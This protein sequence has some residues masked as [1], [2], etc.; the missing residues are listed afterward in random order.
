MGKQDTKHKNT[1]KKQPHQPHKTSKRYLSSTSSNET[2][3]RKNTRRNK[4]SSSSVNVFEY[5]DSFPDD[6]SPTQITE[7]RVTMVTREDQLQSLQ[8]S[9]DRISDK[10]GSID[11]INVKLSNI[12][13]KIDVYCER[14][15][16]IE[17]RL[18]NIVP[19]ISNLSN[20][21]SNISTTLEFLPEKCVIMTP[22][23]FTPGEQL[24]DIANS[25]LQ[26]ITPRDMSH[27]EAQRVKRV[28]FSE[29]NSRPGM[30]LV[31]LNNVDD[32][33]TIL[34]NTRAL[35]F[36]TNTS[37]R[38]IYVRAA[39]S[40]A[41]HKM[42]KNL[43]RLMDVIPGANERFML[44][45]N[46]WLQQRPLNQ[47]VYSAQ[48]SN[49]Q[50]H[51]Y[52]NNSQDYRYP[53]QHQQQFNPHF[54]NNQSWRHQPSHNQH[55]QRGHGSSNYRYNRP[56]QQTNHRQQPPQMVTSPAR[57]ATTH[58]GSPQHT[59]METGPHVIASDRQQT[60]LQ[61]PQLL[62]QH[63]QQTVEQP[64]Q[65]YPQQQ[66]QQSTQQ[67]LPQ[68]HQQPIQQPPQHSLQQPQQ[69]PIQQVGQQS[70]QQPL[71]QPHQQPIQ[72]TPNHSLQQPRQQ[73]FQQP[74]QQP[75]Q[76]VPNQ[77]PHSL[78]SSGPGAHTMNM[79][80]QSASA[81]YNMSNNNNVT[82]QQTLF[83][84]QNMGG[85]PRRDVPPEQALTVMQ[86]VQPHNQ[87]IEHNNVHMNNS[88]LTPLSNTAS[89]YSNAANVL[90]NGEFPVLQ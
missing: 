41:E 86:T 8:N 64:L 26:V 34:S 74:P 80:D 31:E 46:G 5:L 36:C 23:P 48:G 61:Q 47:G 35:K 4:S 39:K 19:E 25:V 56:T 9:I 75:P 33:R 50:V 45:S 28:N 38:A 83:Q 60:H 17:N 72:Q 69:Q 63:S 52:N 84:S 2:P 76:Q 55:Y 13:H 1:S 77:N 18:D 58:T 65:Q 40:Y 12:E 73:L 82:A 20:K 49:T 32:R 44:S 62:T 30:L 71:T 66:S 42:E 3:S 81:L 53:S 87:L 27:I 78:S 22:V 67:P 43:R 70:P 11:Q 57:I 16:D 79:I 85:K 51:S 37:I 24:V 6:Y 54:M 89:V 68:P 10:L 90:H 59:S 14:V 15:V 29:D 88:D 21:V 7:E